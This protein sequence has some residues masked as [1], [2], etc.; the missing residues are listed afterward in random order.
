MALVPFNDLMAQAQQGGYAVGYFESWNLESLLAVADAA[1]A[2]RSPVLLGFSGIYLPHSRRLRADPLSAYAALGLDVCRSLTVPAALVYNES[3]DLASVGRAVDLGFSLVM[4]S[5][6]ALAPDDRIPRIRKLAAYAHQREVA[7]EGELAALPGLTGE[8]PSG[9]MNEALT[10]P[11]EARTFLEATGV[12]AIAVNIGQ[13]HLHGRREVGLNLSLLES[14]GKEIKAPMV[15]HGATSIL[16][17]DLK[18]AISLGIR[19]VNFGSRLKQ[20]YFHAL[21]EACEAVPADYNPYEV[22][23]SGLSTDVLMRAR[24]A[25]QDTVENLMAT[26]GS[27]GKAR[28]AVN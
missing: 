4:Y 18:Q 2:T 5:D 10:N 14:I 8:A 23:G 25:L 19:K 15:L 1:E 22:V 28:E 16:K 21:R 12:D 20:V 26:L 11:T 3:P 24:L 17:E 7:I 13:I 27:A 6:S 9:P